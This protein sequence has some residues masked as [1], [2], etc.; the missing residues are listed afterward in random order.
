M[1]IIEN[2]KIEVLF[3]SLKAL[4]TASCYI[5]SNKDYNTIKSKKKK[6]VWF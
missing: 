2:L 1:K 6:N 4:V 5:P 3:R